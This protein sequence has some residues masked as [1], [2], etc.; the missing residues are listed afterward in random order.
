MF[1]NFLNI[2][3]GKQ[4]IGEKIPQPLS[5]ETKALA[6]MCEIIFSNVSCKCYIRFIFQSLE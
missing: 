2:P 1:V 5:S 3:V 4:E 6:V